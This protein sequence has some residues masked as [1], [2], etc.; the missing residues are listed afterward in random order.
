MDLITAIAF[1]SIVII[2]GLG[3]AVLAAR[4]LAHTGLPTHRPEYSGTLQLTDGLD[5]LHGL[6]LALA[7]RRCGCVYE[8]GHKPNYT[9]IETETLPIAEREADDHAAWNVY[10]GYRRTNRCHHCGETY[11]FFYY[12][13]AHRGRYDVTTVF[14]DADSPLSAAEQV[15]RAD[16]DY[17]DLDHVH[18]A[19][20][21]EALPN[22]GFHGVSTTG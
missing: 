10:K 15:R 17:G 13:T 7:S 5:R 12:K 6:V 3:V 14:P 21:I 8:K 2:V 11:T 20:D 19:S 22:T 1:A 16:V 18:L 9:E 4:T